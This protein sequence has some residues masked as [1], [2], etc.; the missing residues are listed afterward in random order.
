MVLTSAERASLLR[1][2][3]SGYLVVDKK[4][5]PRLVQ[6]WVKWCDEHKRISKLKDVATLDEWIA[7]RQAGKSMQ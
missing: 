2:K 7:A 4:F 1:A 5:I 3:H 6:A